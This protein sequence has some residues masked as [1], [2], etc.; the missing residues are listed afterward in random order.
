MTF[1][2]ERAANPLMLVALLTL[3]CGCQKTN[4]AT[5]VAP[6]PTEK[7]A[8]YTVQTKDVA[9]V[10]GESRVATLLLAPTA[11]WKYNDA[12]PTQLS[13]KPL[14]A[15]GSVSLQKTTFQATDVRMAEGNATIG[16]ALKG[17]RSGE[18]TMAGTVKFSLCVKEKC[19]L[20]EKDVSWNIRVTQASR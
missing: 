19:V 10:E 8:I 15:D 4:T 14:G 9:I 13:L 7:S 5:P 12:Y 18:E 3:I 1:R 11:P 16:I 17:V 20:R 2:L 6:T